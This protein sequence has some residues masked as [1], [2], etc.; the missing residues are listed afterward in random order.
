MGIGATPGNQGLLLLT[1]IVAFIA[2]PVFFVAAT[3]LVGL[4]ERILGIKSGV[5]WLALLLAIPGALL[6]AWLVLDQ[7]GEALS[8]QVIEKTEQVVVNDD[9]GWMDRLSLQLRYSVSGQPL[10]PFTST[11]DALTQATDRSNPQ[12]LVTLWTDSADFDRLRPG[13]TVA[14]RV[15]R[16]NSR[17]SLVRL[18]NQS[19]ATFLPWAYVEIGVG[20]VALALIAWRLRHTPLGY[21]P[22]L[23]LGM[24]AL[25]AP[26]AYAYQAWTEAEDL[27]RA[28]D[29]ATATVKTTTRVTEISMSSSEGP[30]WTTNVPQP[31]DVVQL[32]F[33]PAGYRDTV[34]AVDA[35]DV[36][37]SQPS[38]FEPGALVDVD[39]VP[40]GPRSARIPGQT[41]THAL[42]TTLGIYL[43]GGAVVLGFLALIALAGVVGR[44]LLKVVLS[45]LF[46]RR[47]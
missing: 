24:V 10:P 41:R 28:T 40:G 31:Y 14:L 32:A 44:M 26:L 47:K 18:A 46:R 37:A 19:T 9:G 21:G 42:K 45:L 11:A 25:A 43:Q 38:R 15:L 29:R 23:V 33:V 6:A 2:L 35:V 20:V 39:Y 36:P 4:V 22:M 5:P 34:I 30:D 1:S 17:F 8:G 3:N 7:D 16:A 13:D 12:E 27:S